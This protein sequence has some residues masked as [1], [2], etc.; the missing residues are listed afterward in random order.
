V[1]SGLAG[2]N[3]YA[4]HSSHSSPASSMS[5]HLSASFA[6]LGPLISQRNGGDA[7][8][9]AVQLTVAQQAAQ[10]AAVSGAHQQHTTLADGFGS[11]YLLQEQ[12]VVEAGSPTKCQHP[13]SSTA[14]DCRHITMLECG[15]CCFHAA[16][17]GICVKLHPPSPPH[18][19]APWSRQVCVC[20]CCAAHTSLVPISS[21]MTTSGAW[22]CT[23]STSTCACCCLLGTIMRRA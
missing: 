21:M 11:R 10:A 6:G 7:S 8:H 15:S 2:T 13:N 20:P 1:P 4:V 19:A 3:C 9:Q 14:A 22:F 12:R 18:T 16:A 23:A 5:T 17:K